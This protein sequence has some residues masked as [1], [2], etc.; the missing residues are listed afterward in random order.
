MEQCRMRE[1]LEHKL[2]M[3]MRERRRVTIDALVLGAVLLRIVSADAGAPL[4]LF[5]DLGGARQCGVAATKATLLIA[6]CRRLLLLHAVIQPAVVRLLC[7][8]HHFRT[9]RFGTA[10]MQFPVHLACTPA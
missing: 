7:K 6:P 4:C 3:L 10:L 2:K 1:D 8:C 5:V 9:Q